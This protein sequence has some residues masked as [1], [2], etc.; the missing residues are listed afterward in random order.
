MCRAVSCR[1]VS[2]RVSNYQTSKHLNIQKSGNLFE[3]VTVFRNCILSKSHRTSH[4]ASLTYKILNDGNHDY[5]EIFMAAFFI[6]LA[7]T[8]AWLPLAATWAWRA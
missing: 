7:A 1:V 4:I 3:V 6:T 8:W 5:T 2:C